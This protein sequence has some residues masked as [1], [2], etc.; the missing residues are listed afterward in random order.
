MSITRPAAAAT[1]GVPAGAAMS[2]PLCGLRAW[3]LNTR[4]SPNELERAPGTG[5]RIRSDAGTS[6]LGVSL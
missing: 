6:S 5:W 2:I 3:P 1:T 4:R